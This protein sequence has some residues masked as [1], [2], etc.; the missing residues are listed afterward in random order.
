MQM[1]AD[2]EDIPKKLKGMPALFNTLSGD[3]GGFREQIA[4]GAF[5]ETIVND[6]IRCLWNHDSNHVLGRTASGTLR[7]S[8]TV[9]GL[10]MENDLP[11]THCAEDLAESIARGD[12]NQMSFGFQ[13]M[14]DSWNM[15]GEEM[16]RTLLKVK[17][18]DVSPV[19]FPAYVDTTVGL[20]S[21]E[22]YRKT[23]PHAGAHDGVEA[24]VY[25]DLLGEEDLIYRSMMNI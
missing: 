19:T 16:I 23:A 12:V 10:S 2:Q 20:R 4:P 6:D 14:E 3:L 15:V 7:L 17:L 8:E 9:Q 25:T 11:D 21:L 24:K 22:E 13:T 5:S 18:Y 1:V